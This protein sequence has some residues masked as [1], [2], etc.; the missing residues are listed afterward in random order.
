MLNLNN[1]HSNVCIVSYVGYLYMVNNY[2]SI[3][4]KRLILNNNYSNVHKGRC[5]WDQF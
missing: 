3:N 2:L 4:T 5:Q 1:N